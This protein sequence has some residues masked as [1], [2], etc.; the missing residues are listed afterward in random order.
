MYHIE[1]N[2]SSPRRATSSGLTEGRELFVSVEVYVPNK[3]AGSSSRRALGQKKKSDGKLDFLRPLAEEGQRKLKEKS[4]WLNLTRNSTVA[5]Q[6]R[7]ATCKLSEEGDSCV[8]RVYLEETTLC[9]TIQI[10]LLNHTDIRH[11]D[12]SLFCRRSCLGIHCVPGQRWSSAGADAP[13]YLYFADTDTLDIWTALL[14]SYAMPEIYGR[15]FSA[16]G[17]LY[18]MWREAKLT[19]IQGRK[20]GV[21]SSGFGASKGGSSSGPSSDIS[22]E[23]PPLHGVDMDVFCEIYINDTLGGRTTVQNA[24]DGLH[25]KETFSFS[26][27]PPFDNLTIVVFRERRLSKPVEVGTVDI[28]LANFR[29]GDRID[30]W[31]PLLRGEPG[32][33]QAQVGELQLSVQVDE[34]IILPYSAYT[35]LHDELN[36]RNCLDWIADLRAHQQHNNLCRAMIA[37]ARSRD[38]LI[39]QI[40]EMASREVEDIT[41]ASQ[42]TLF[43]ASTA[44]SKTMELIMLDTGHSFLEA[45]VGKTIRRLCSEKVA[46]DMDEG[47]TKTAKEMERSS[48]ALA[49]WCQELWDQIYRNRTGCPHELRRVF[50]H[51]RLRVGQRVQAQ[52]GID[53]YPTNDA[54]HAVSAFCFLRF[55]VPAILNPHL[56]G[57]IPGLPELAVRRSLT[58]I[59]KYIQTLAN[60]KMSFSRNDRMPR[61]KT[62]ISESL[63]QMKDYILYIST[64]VLE[65]RKPSIIPG[66]ASAVHGRTHALHVLRERRQSLPM[67]AREAIS[68]PTLFLDVPKHLAVVSSAV[69]RQTQTTASTIDSRSRHEPVIALRARCF[70]VEE[71]ALRQVNKLANLSRRSP[72]NVSILTLPNPGYPSHPPRQ[73]APS[74]AARDATTRGSPRSRKLSR[75]STA[76]SASGSELSLPRDNGLQLPGS[77][78][79]SQRRDSEPKTAISSGPDTTDA[80]VPPRAAFVRTSH[81][82]AASTESALKC[83]ESADEGL[84][85]HISNSLVPDDANRKKKNLFRGILSRR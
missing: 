3:G 37:L 70:K 2:P 8:L 6:W 67:L 42:N 11:A 30:G 46:L 21:M 35:E 51:I 84:S 20:L 32:S 23:S 82:K 27:M 15:P 62:F 50:E 31:W 38:V 36:S 55:I 79:I 45:S 34:E 64:P 68:H 22:P 26:D 56:F 75:P 4:S 78:L 17:G 52:P 18:R 5:G 53:G 71:R 40:M 28:V 33:T 69:I 41:L 61:V 16:E 29:R 12:K 85:S 44:L 25:Y 72:G 19:V 39:D 80:L 7:P 54:L 59:A 73:K 10:H 83:V 48:D 58:H 76:P 14:R 49:D 24:V 13:V 43:R 1:S 77:S 9:H 74:S 60:L 47:Q 66:T 57:L 81:Q 63:P 65:Q